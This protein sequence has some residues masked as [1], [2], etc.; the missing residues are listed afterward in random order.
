MRETQDAARTRR[1]QIRSAAR[2][3]GE[4]LRKA[5]RVVPEDSKPAKP[6]N[7]GK[8]GLGT[9]PSDRLIGIG[10]MCAALAIFSVLDATAKWASQHM[11]PIQAVWARYLVSVLLVTA[12]LNPLSRPG[13]MSTR[14]PG[15]QSLRSM[16]LLLSTVLN[17][18]ALQFLQLA[19]A[20]TIIF[21][22]PLLI[23][24]LSGP[25][26]GEWPGPRRMVAIG[27]G[28]LG[29]LVVMRPGTGSLHPAALL[30]MAGVVCYAFYNLTTRKLASIDSSETTMVYSGMAGV[31]LITPLMPWF[32]TT[33][34]SPALWGAMVLM[35]ACGAFG[36][37]L[38]IGAH[39]RAPASV[40]APFIYTQLIWMLI[41]G[42][43]VFGQWPDTWTLAGGS[44]VVASG[45]YL[46]Y[47]ERVRGADVNRVA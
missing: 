45:L 44:I 21:A 22:T 32:W 26:L 1:W 18:F 2:N 5:E 28:F 7:L 39:R 35:G 23:A 12:L 4:R 10:L 31:L 17:F 20:I 34:T 11:H 41:L 37:W 15:L 19:E 13:V 24:L 46:L 8:P 38:I 9:G 16:M 43:L 25:L 47:R 36:H 40:L 29:V 14:A 6:D 27:V 42:W 30:S 33:P 3:V